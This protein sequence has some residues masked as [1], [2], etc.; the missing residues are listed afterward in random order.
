VGIDVTFMVDESDGTADVDCN[1]RLS[2]ARLPRGG[3]LE[4]KG[5]DATALEY[6]AHRCCRLGYTVFG[7]GQPVGE[8]SLSV[9]K[10]GDRRDVS[11]RAL[12]PDRAAGRP[13]SVGYTWSV[14]GHSADGL[15]IR[16]H[17]GK[18]T[19]SAGPAVSFRPDGP[20]PSAVEHLLAALAG[21][22]LSSFASSLRERG[23]EFDAL[24][25]RLSCQL[26][27]PLASIGVVGA[28]GS[29]AVSGIGGVVYVSADTEEPVLRGA[30]CA[31]I[32]RSPLFNTL[33]PCLA[34][35]ID[36]R[37]EL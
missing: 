19:F 28:E 2:L 27:D 37:P 26:D 3:V 10:G 14:R 30:W 7:G 31:A 4:L 13:D 36:M 8:V 21:D 12:G 16:L 18:H 6:L 22:L 9:A 23:I 34:L 33:A 11:G 1:L 5:A 25:C 17:A 24:E 29:P 15:L 20:L 35:R 32:G